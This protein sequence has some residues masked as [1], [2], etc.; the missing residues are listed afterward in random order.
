M[1]S[2]LQSETFQPLCYLMHF[3]SAHQNSFI[4]PHK[5]VWIKNVFLR[6]FY[7]FIVYI[8]SE[9]FIILYRYVSTAVLDLIVKGFLYMG[10][11]GRM[12]K[13]M[14]GHSNTGW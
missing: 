11:I 7:L 12:F 4:S 8:L 6:L 14:N 5:V 10:P 3:S 1:F 2:Y 9:H 13:C